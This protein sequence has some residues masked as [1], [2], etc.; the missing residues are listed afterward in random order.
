[1]VEVGGGWVVHIH[2]TELTFERFSVVESCLVI[3]MSH[4]IE[5]R[6]SLKA[7]EAGSKHHDVFI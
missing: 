7:L 2:R 1:M 6:V 5:L 3:L 4:D